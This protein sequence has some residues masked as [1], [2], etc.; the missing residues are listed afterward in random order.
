[1]YQIRV[2]TSNAKSSA[3]PFRS[4]AKALAAGLPRQIHV[5]ITTD[6]FVHFYKNE[7]DKTLCKLDSTEDPCSLEKYSTPP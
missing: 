2:G 1:M 6:Q 3:F 5:R 4:H 7:F